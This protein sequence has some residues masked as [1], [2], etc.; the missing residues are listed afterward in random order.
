MS[1]QRTLPGHHAGSTGG[2]FSP[3]I[4]WASLAASFFPSVVSST[5]KLLENFLQL[6][7][8]VFQALLNVWLFVFVLVPSLSKLDF[9][10]DNCVR[11]NLWVYQNIIRNPL[12]G[13][14]LFLFF[15]SCLCVH[16]CL[17]AVQSLVPG[18]P[19]ISRCRHTIMAWGS[20]VSGHW[21]DTFTISLLSLRQ[22]MV[23]A[24]QNVGEIF[25]SW[26]DILKCP[27]L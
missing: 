18:V 8:N 21:L 14:F 16:L 13:I 12:I 7:H 23:S 11:N 6:F 26:A 3:C 9:S 5:S 17:W 2:H 19:G 20:N 10:D 25:C 22:Y 1:V 27:P 4:P 15:L 24:V